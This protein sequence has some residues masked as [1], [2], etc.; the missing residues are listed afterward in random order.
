LKSRLRCR[1]DQRL[2]IQ[3]EE[4]LMTIADEVHPPEEVVELGLVS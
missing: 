1:P 3:I 2:A 4:G